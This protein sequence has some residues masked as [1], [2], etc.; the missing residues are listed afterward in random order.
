MAPGDKNSQIARRRDW[1]MLSWSSTTNVDP[2]LALL[3]EIVFVPY[4]ADLDN[5]ALTVPVEVAGAQAKGQPRL[6]SHDARMRA[7]WSRHIPDA[8]R[9][10][11][12]P[13]RTHTARCAS[14]IDTVSSVGL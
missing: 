2:F 10:G 1:A 7:Y 3:L 9:L 13:R 14:T 6:I 4:V 11:S 12:D 5:R 8:C